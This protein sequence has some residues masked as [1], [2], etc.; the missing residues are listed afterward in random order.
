MQKVHIAHTPAQ[1]LESVPKKDLYVSHQDSKGGVLEIE[2]HAS[3]SHHSKLL[4]D[5]VDN[6]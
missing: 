5:S 3:V 2:N 6:G 4:Q 1:H